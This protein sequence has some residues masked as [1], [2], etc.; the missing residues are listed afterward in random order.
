MDRTTPTSFSLPFG[1]NHYAPNEA[2]EEKPVI[3]FCSK[4][5]KLYKVPDYLLDI[6]IPICPPCYSKWFTVSPQVSNKVAP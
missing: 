4:C 5:Y 1:R 6:F 3:E 2:F